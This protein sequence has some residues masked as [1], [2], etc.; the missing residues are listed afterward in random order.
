MRCNACHVNPS[1]GYHTSNCD[2]EWLARKQYNRALVG[3]KALTKACHGRRAV[4]HVSPS[5]NDITHCL[6]AY[7]CVTSSVIMLQPCWGVYSL[8]AL[9]SQ[10]SEPATSRQALLLHA[11]LSSHDWGDK[12]TWR[13]PCPGAERLSE[14][15]QGNRSGL[16]VP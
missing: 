14:G 8:Q 9:I 4:Q 3:R 5:M 10:A 6:M 2:V 7:L 11:L 16:L 13:C 12:G 1:R 15:V